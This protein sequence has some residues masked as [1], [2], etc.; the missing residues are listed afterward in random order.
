LRKSPQNAS[1][2]AD[3]F[4]AAVGVLLNATADYAATSP[5]RIGFGVHLDTPTIFSLVQCVPSLT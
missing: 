2:L 4:D 5:M 3:V 1:T